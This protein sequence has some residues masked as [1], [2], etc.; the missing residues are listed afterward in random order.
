MKLILNEMPTS[1]PTPIGIQLTQL[2][3][4]CINQ[5]AITKI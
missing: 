5:L 1:V 3:N 4:N 2:K